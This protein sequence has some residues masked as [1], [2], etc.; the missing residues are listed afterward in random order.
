[1]SFLP[2]PIPTLP[3]SSGTAGQA[4]H[5]ASLTAQLEE[6]VSRNNQFSKQLQ[7]ERAESERRVKAERQR[8]DAAV[9]QLQQANVQEIQEWKDACESL[10]TASKHASMSMAYVH[11]VTNYDLLVSTQ[12]CEDLQVNLRER[13]MELFIA[14]GNITDLSYRIE[15]MERANS[16]RVQELLLEI[17]NAHAELDTAQANLAATRTKISLR[18]DEKLSDMKKR[19]QD[20]IAEKESLEVQLTKFQ[21]EMS[22]L[23]QSF[24]R[25]R[26]ESKDD[27]REKKEL[28]REMRELKDQVADWKRLEG[29]EADSL[30]D[31]KKKLRELEV[32]LSSEQ[33]RVA[34]LEKENARL[35]KDTVKERLRVEK[36]KEEVERER[37][38]A[39]QALK[40]IR[41]ELRDSR[42]ATEDAEK[43]NLPEPLATAAKTKGATKRSREEVDAPD[44]D[45]RKHTTKKVKHSE[46]P[47]KTTLSKARKVAKASERKGSPAFDA[48]DE[49]TEQPPKKMKKPFKPAQKKA[50]E[51][52]EESEDMNAKRAKYFGV[53]NVGE[54]QIKQSKNQST[55]VKGTLDDSADED[56]LLNK[57]STAK[58]GLKD[59]NNGISKSGV[60]QK[61]KPKAKKG[62]IGAPQDSDEAEVFDIDAVSST[63]EEEGERFEADL[64]EPV[65]S[66][67][68][69]GL[70]G[71][72]ISKRSNPTKGKGRVE[73]KSV[74]PAPPTETAKPKKRTL[75]LLAGTV[76]GGGTVSSWWDNAEQNIFNI[77]TT[78]S[79]P[80]KGGSIVPRFQFGRGK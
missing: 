38:D 5:I 48:V 67:Q 73:G 44:D 20:S 23:E 40:D 10:C 63:D 39:K 16:R 25:L 70:A 19:L 71:D 68:A 72:N 8:G 9:R 61:G 65:K 62:H 7:D 18:E 34:E 3:I 55:S 77:P 75:N 29:K 54:G 33:D 1:M 56:G 12:Q 46:E 47:E 15:D 6:L 79:S 51:E 35:R 27:K 74:V 21:S 66:K 13:E 4:A 76:S 42:K 45:G 37:D 17:E 24:E 78:L 2:T 58:A 49:G 64:K 50:L 36:E 60:N 14:N 31:M 26:L 28:E 69:T 32:S 43:E 30:K 41:R 11:S 53:R 80:E 52:D 57:Q 22:T 59:K